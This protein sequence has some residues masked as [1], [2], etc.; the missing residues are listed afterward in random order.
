MSGEITPQNSQNPQNTP[1]D[2][3]TERQRLFVEAYC[4]VAL[5]NASEAARRAG[6]SPKTANEQGA[7]LLADVSIRAA[8]EQRMREI[9]GAMGAEEVI[10]RLS[11]IARL[12]TLSF[13]DIDP[14]GRATIN[15][16]YV[17]AAG[18]GHLVKGVKFDKYG[19]QVVDWHD[20]VRAL[21]SL[22]KLHKLFVDKVEQQTETRLVVEFEEPLTQDANSEDPDAPDSEE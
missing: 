2:T 15:L 12:D 13:A 5:G 18:L 14:S 9:R 6:Y 17:R 3:L 11:D 4:G 19:N 8:V 10:Q 21:E 16:N 22:G 7:R 1:N 20:P